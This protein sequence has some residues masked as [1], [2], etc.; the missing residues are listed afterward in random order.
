MEALHVAD[1]GCHRGRRGSAP[2]ET[3]WQHKRCFSSSGLFRAFTLVELLVV[4][5]IIGILIA[6]LLPAVQAA[7]EAARR[8]QCVNNLKQIGLALHNYHNA[9]RVLPYGSDWPWCWGGTWHAFILPYIELQSLYNQFDFRKKMYEAPNKELVKTVV[10]IYLCPSD[11][12]SSRPVLTGRRLNSPL[13][14]P[15]EA[16]AVSY[17][18]CMGP[19][20]PDFC[21]FCPDRNPSASNWCCQGYNLGSQSSSG[22]WGASSVG[23]FGRFAKS[24]RFEDAT[25]GLSN[26]IMAG[27]TLPAHCIWNGAFR[28]NFPVSSTNIPINTMET[29]NGEERDYWRTSGYKSKHPG[30]CNL[31]MGDGSVHFCSETIDFQVYNYLG[32]RAGGELA[33]LP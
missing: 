20:H 7:R 13:C 33:R 24:F 23:M 21:D 19:T 6:L 10:P 9:L 5:T 11:P 15:P 25:D 17:T 8:A 16:S 4:I 27:E 3:L 12:I 28:H 2:Q 31:L 18:A 22:V 26:T 32:T 29:D 14:D 1:R 30:G